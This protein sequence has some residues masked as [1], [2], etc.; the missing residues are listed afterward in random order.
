MSLARPLFGLGNRPFERFDAFAAS[1][2]GFDG[3]ES[4]IDT[5]LCAIDSVDHE[6][7]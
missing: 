1:V 4:S 5:I 3:G 2:V 7:A 6:L